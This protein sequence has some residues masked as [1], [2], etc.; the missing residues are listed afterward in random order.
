MT[1]E[2]VPQDV[3]EDIDRRWRELEQ[4][5]VIEKEMEQLEHFG[6][7]TEEPRSDHKGAAL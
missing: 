5:R 1:I 3:Q 4:D 7:V 6:L 2:E